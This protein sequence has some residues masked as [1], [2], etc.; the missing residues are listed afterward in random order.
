MTAR[1]PT[2]DEGVKV[3]DEPSSEDEGDLSSSDED[4][5]WDSDGVVLTRS[6]TIDIVYSGGDSVK[7]GRRRYGPTGCWTFSVAWQE[8]R[9][10]MSR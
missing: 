4:V 8:Q 3:G 6:S 7:M 1:E 9:L 10:G 5:V 2:S